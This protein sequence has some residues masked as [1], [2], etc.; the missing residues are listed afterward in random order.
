M[1]ASDK[2]RDLLAKLV[3]PKPFDTRERW[4]DAVARKAGISF[5]AAR[6][7]YYGEINDPENKAY[8][9]VTDKILER[10]KRAG[11]EHDRTMQ[12]SAAIQRRSRD[13]AAELDELAARIAEIRAELGLRRTD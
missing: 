5:S 10:A 6:R 3:E 11:A 4:L 12:E 1:H 8:R 2:P 13:L 9:R 7:I